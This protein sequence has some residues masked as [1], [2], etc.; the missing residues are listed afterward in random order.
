MLIR[1]LRRPVLGSFVL[2]FSLSAIALLLLASA[3]QPSHAQE[4]QSK[5]SGTVVDAEGKPIEG[6]RVFLL[7]VPRW[8]SQGQPEPESVEG[9][10]TDAEG[11]FSI[12]Y[13]SKLRWYGVVYKPNLV[14]Y[15]QGLA[16]C[17]LYTSPSP[18]DQRGSRMPSS[19]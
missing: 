19:A 16:A 17:L 18:R 1:N 10:P 13:D 11:N 4:P 3:A 6:A 12:A 9:K 2:S 7:P 15:F 8:G 5:F 14:P